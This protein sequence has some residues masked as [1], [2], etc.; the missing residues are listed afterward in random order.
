MSNVSKQDW[1][2]WHTEYDEPGSVLSLRLAAIQR[3]ITE[4]LDRAPAGPLKA[5]SMCAGQGRDLIGALAGHSRRGDTAAVLV[6][7]NSLNA[8]RARADATAAG[9]SGV[10]VVTGDAARTDNYVGY[11]PAYLVLVC[12]V[13]GNMSDANVERTIGYCTQLC[14]TGGTVIWTRGR[15]EPDL[16]PQVCTW[17][18][19]R[20]FERLWV[21]EPG[22]PAGVGAH[23][24]MGTPEPLE[25]GSAM[26]D[27][28]GHDVGRGPQRR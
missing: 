19:E 28:T 21:S 13:F 15:W 9:L 6:E 4:A 5:I 2:T 27:F 24:F 14:A 22:F 1:V 25:L 26:F 18:E 23:R 3:L 8:E 20:G 10:E 12:G 7:L 11:V 16:F 17:Y